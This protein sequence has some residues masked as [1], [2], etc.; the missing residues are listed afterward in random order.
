[1][2]TQP[3]TAEEHART[4]LTF[5]DQSGQEFDAGDVLQ[6][7]EKLW[8]AASHAVLAVSRQRGWPVGSHRATVDAALSL[9]RELNEPLLAYEFAIAQRFHMKFYGANMF[10][11]FDETDAMEEGQE[12]VADFVRRLIAIVEESRQGPIAG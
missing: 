5:L 7:S 3:M 2:T 10:N 6:G 8:G 12:L 9:A 1:M 11:P 4:A